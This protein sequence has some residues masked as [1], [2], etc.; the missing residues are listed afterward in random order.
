M[1]V[2]AIGA[3]RG[4][5]RQ[6]LRQKLLLADFSVG[7]LELVLL[8]VSLAGKSSVSGFAIE[9]AAGAMIERGVDVNPHLGVRVAQI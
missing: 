7:W 2:D 8:G 1:L 6:P 3:S 4:G 5:T 9:I